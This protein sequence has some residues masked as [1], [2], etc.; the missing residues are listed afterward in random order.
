MAAE[1][2]NGDNTRNMMAAELGTIHKSLYGQLPDG[3]EVHQYCLGN[4]QGMRASIINYGGIITE[5]HVPD[6]HGQL[7]DV[8]LGYDSLAQYQQDKFYLGA[9]LGRYAGRIAGGRLSIAGN[10]YVLPGNNDGNHLHG[11]DSGF[12]RVLWQAQSRQGDEGPSLVLCHTSPDG[13]QG[14]PGNLQVEVTYTL[15]RHNELKVQ[16]RARCDKLTVLNL[17]QHSYFNLSGDLGAPVL[18][19]RLRVNADRFLQ[20][21]SRLIP[22]GELLSVSATPFDFRADRQ[23]GERIHMPHEQLIRGNGY[24]HTWVLGVAPTQSPEPV[25]VLYDPRS[26]R[27]LSVST[28]EPGLQV[29]TANFL[30]NC[31]VGKNGQTLNRR[32]AVC[33]ETQHFPDSPNRPLF[34]STL[35]HPGEQFE[36]HTWFAFGV[37]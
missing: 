2:D 19:H 24:D 37:G 13:E 30:D 4:A 6:R 22:S 32:A 12:N 21:D 8:V 36:S 11:G 16:Y 5:L 31:T 14:Y 33:L 23:L 26:G 17:S 15:T 29:Y 27:K 35:L 34:P 10:H 1:F 9:V 28:T 7:A 18:D 20:L 25:A 3:R